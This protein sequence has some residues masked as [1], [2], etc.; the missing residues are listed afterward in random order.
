MNN[1]DKVYRSFKSVVDIIE[2]VCLSTHETRAAVAEAFQFGYVLKV[3]ES[4]SHKY[5]WIIE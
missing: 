1:E 3:D 4:K 5:I 2:E